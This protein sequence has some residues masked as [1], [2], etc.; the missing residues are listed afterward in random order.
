M[1]KINNKNLLLYL[2]VKHILND[3]IYKKYS[4]YMSK[5]KIR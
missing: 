5:N 3:V 1:T 2:H 4:Q